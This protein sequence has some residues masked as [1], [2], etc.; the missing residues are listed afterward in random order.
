MI[1]NLHLLTPRATCARARIVSIF[2]PIISPILK[3]F[4]PIYP[5]PKTFL[6]KA[7]QID[8]TWYPYVSKILSIFLKLMEFL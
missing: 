1:V 8:E 2:C 4:G 6:S 5:N 7:P 3:R